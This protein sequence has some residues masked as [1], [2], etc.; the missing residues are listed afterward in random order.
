MA[1]ARNSGW[2]QVRT[3]LV[4]ASTA[5][6][7]PTR[8]SGLTTLA[9]GRTPWRRR[10]GRARRAAGSSR[11]ATTRRTRGRARCPPATRS[12]PLR[13][14][15]RLRGQDVAV[16]LRIIEDPAGAAD[17]AGHRVFIEMDRQAGLLLQE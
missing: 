11:R 15:S 6:T 3:T 16:F 14:P 7:T 12:D 1:L 10:P 17:H 4:C 2:A 5:E 9:S 8:P 13:A